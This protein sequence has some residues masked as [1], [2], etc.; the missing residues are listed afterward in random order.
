[1]HAKHMTFTRWKAAFWR[2][3]EREGKLLAFDA[4]GDGAMLLFYE[5]GVEP[6]VQ[7]ILKDA[8]LGTPETV[9]RKRNAENNLRTKPLD[10]Q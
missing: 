5:R 6:T 8:L 2:D 1:M 10:R 3:C 4:M 7:G 9:K